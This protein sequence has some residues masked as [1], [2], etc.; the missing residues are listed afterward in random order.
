[1]SCH[2]SRSGP[3]GAN[4]CELLACFCN[5]TEATFADSELIDEVIQDF[6]LDLSSQLSASQAR[7]RE[8]EE[9]IRKALGMV[10]PGSGVPLRDRGER[11]AR[12]FLARLVGYE[13]PDVAEI[14][15]LDRTALNSKRGE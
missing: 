12:E 3:K 11:E 13:V 2:W 5:T 7:V 8:L 14:W 9:G 1:M 10:M 6:Y 15:P 4:V